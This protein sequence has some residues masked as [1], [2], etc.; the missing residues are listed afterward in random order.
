MLTDVGVLGHILV[1]LYPL[2]FLL[3]ESW[4]KEF[5]FLLS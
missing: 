1:N 2:R 3:Q 4:S 5:G